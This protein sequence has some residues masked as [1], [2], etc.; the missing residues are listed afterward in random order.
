VVFPGHHTGHT[1]GRDLSLLALVQTRKVKPA[2]CTRFGRKL[3]TDVFS[4]TLSP[5]HPHDESWPGPVASLAAPRVACFFANAHA[6]SSRMRAGGEPKHQPTVVV[7]RCVR[8]RNIGV[9]Y[10]H[11]A[12]QRLEEEGN[13]PLVGGLNP[14]VLI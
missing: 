4:G 1:G 14:T 12:K 3:G 11:E 13:Q 5:R 7:L 8:D 9:M 2:D 6:F 10:A